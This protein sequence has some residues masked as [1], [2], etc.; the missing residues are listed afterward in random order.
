MQ[1]CAVDSEFVGVN[2]NDSCRLSA[3]A[4]ATAQAGHPLATFMWGNKRSLYTVPLQQGIAIRDRIMQHYRRH[5]SASCMCLTVL[6]GH[7]L[8]ELQAWVEELFGPVRPPPSWPALHSRR[9]RRLRSVRSDCAELELSLRLS[10]CCMPP[11][12]RRLL[13]GCLQPRRGCSGRQRGQGAA[14]G[15]RRCRPRHVG[16][17]GVT[18]HRLIAAECHIRSHDWGTPWAPQRRT[19][20]AAPAAHAHPLV[21]PPVLWPP[22]LT[23]PRLSRSLFCLDPVACERYGAA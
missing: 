14:A 21:K 7:T 20:H 1:V 18:L 8:A 13:P 23:A 5:Y 4:A 17:W 11:A 12:S 15:R 3:V 9:C 19:R 16:S 2:Q 22:R 10:D 6:G